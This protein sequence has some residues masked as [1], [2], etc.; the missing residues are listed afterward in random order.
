[1]IQTEKLSSAKK[2]KIHASTYIKYLGVFI[3]GKTLKNEIFIK[4]EL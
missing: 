1:M 4:M 2:K 3:D